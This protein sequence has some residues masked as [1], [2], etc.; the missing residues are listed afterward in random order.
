M[1][2]VIWKYV[3]FPGDVCVEAPGRV[4]PLAVG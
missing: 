4:R 3:L 1:R 2:Q